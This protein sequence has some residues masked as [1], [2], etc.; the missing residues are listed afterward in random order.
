MNFNIFYNILSIHKQFF[1]LNILQNKLDFTFFLRLKA[2]CKSI[3]PIFEYRIKLSQILY[4]KKKKINF[5]M[6][7][8][9]N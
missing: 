8:Y 5:H 1:L 6:Y 7:K 2:L 4:D 3:Q 9:F